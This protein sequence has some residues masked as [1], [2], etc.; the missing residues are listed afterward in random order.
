[1]KINGNWKMTKHWIV[2]VGICGSVAL[3]AAC[4]VNPFDVLPAAPNPFNPMPVTAPLT[5][6]AGNDL[7]ATQEQT[8]TLEAT[9]SGGSPP[10]IFRWNVEL[11]PDDPLELLDGVIP[12][13]ADNNQ[14]TIDT[15]PFDIGQYVYRIRVT[16]STGRTAVD[17]VMIDVAETPLRVTIAESGDDADVPLSAVAAEAFTLTADTN[18][19]GDFT[20]IWAQIDGP[21]AEFSNDDQQSI[22]VTASEPGELVIR[23][24]VQQDGGGAAFVDVR[25]DVV[26]GDSFLVRVEQPD[27]LLLGE[28]DSLTANISNDT[29]DADALSYSWEVVDGRDVVF[30]SPDARTTDVTSNV[31]QTIEVRVTASGTVNGRARENSE[32]VV[33]VVLPDLN[34]EFIMTV[35]SLNAGVSGNV[36]FAFDAQA[37]PKTVANIVRYID[38]AFYNDTLWH[39]V[40]TRTGM[41][42]PGGVV[43]ADIPFVAQF[44]GFRRAGDVVE[45]LDVR[46]PV[47]SENETSLGSTPRT[48]AVALS[49]G[50]PDSG[51]S[52]I[53]V[54]V[55]D[56]SN[57]ETDDVNHVDLDSQGFTAFGRV[58][59]GFGLI[60]AM[61]DAQVDNAD[62]A[63][64]PSLTNV[65]VDDI[66]ILV[67]RRAIVTE[68]D[69]GDGGSF[70]GDGGAG[71]V[72]G[73][74]AG[75]GDR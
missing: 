1:M 7:F 6:D 32:N 54:N 38:D 21:N 22:E 13:L 56:N 36:T 15:V 73:V 10:Y 65:P 41:Q 68:V 16:D 39:R 34:P 44:G 48:I 23:V 55:S 74:F 52:Q 42:S 28:A 72:G 43:G 66:T 62:T 49:G 60:E 63:D 50:N 45:R 67:F 17:F 14:P 69:R 51:T 26:Q 53:F 30:S 8:L 37:A 46:D 12:L 33:L 61:F 71:G 3:L 29:V 35:S 11:V 59:E 20:Y 4:D 64:G 47:V 58:V 57:I 24:T 9:A 2:L 40:V 5:V 27:L 31:L 18:M 75:I 25:V 70:F 19:T